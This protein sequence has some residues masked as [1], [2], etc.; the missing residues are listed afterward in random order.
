MFIDLRLTNSKYGYFSHVLILPAGTISVY[1]NKK[2][3]ANV[4]SHFLQY[5]NVQFE[6][7]SSVTVSVAIT[8]S[9]AISMRAITV[10]LAVGAGLGLG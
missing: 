2:M 10:T 1:Q 3:G 6:L 7:G 9:I 5:E 4:R 8:V